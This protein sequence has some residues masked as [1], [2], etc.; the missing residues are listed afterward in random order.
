MNIYQQ[1]LLQLKGENYE[2]INKSI[3]YYDVKPQFKMHTQN[4]LSFFYKYDD[5]QENGEEDVF[6]TEE[7]IEAIDKLDY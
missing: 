5:D 2:A 7:Q 3:D 1:I 4:N 6:M